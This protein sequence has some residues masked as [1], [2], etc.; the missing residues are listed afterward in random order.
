VENVDPFKVFARDKWHC[1]DCGV[2]TPRSKRGSYDADAPELDHI[3]PLSKGGAHSYKNTQCL[4]RRC[5]QEKSD[6][7][8][9]QEVESLLQ[10]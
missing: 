2:A 6:T 10:A 3:K 7:W 5:N 1:Q 4:C 8:Q 9:P